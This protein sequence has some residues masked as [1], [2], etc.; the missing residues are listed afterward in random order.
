M[1]W[2][3]DS[4]APLQLLLSGISLC[5]MFVGI[6]FLMN[7]PK[8]TETTELHRG[9]Y[10]HGIYFSWAGCGPENSFR[11]HREFGLILAEAE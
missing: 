7:P 4:A 5:E 11:E 8:S 1:P 10:W 3:P 6:S 2:H 9:F